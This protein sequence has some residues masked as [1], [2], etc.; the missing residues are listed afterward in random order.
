M[1]L[2]LWLKKN[3]K[4]SGRGKLKG[5][6]L[7]LANFLLIATLCVV[8]VV[9]LPLSIVW[10][11]VYITKTSQYQN[12]LRDSLSVLQKKLTT[13]T[14]KAEQLS[15]VERVE[16]IAKVFLEL[17]YPVSKNIVILRPRTINKKRKF[18]VKSPFWTV[19]KKSIAPE[20]G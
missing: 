17:D 16:E 14:I 19:L 10:K 9:M 2:K 20:K 4:N 18:V 7:P 6:M 1:K 15:S 8:V 12:D 13:L 11:Q 3:V 5:E